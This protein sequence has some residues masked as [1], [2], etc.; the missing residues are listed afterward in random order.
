MII[1]ILQGCRV[2]RGMSSA[3]RLPAAFLLVSSAVLSAIRVIMSNR[4]RGYGSGA[5]A[6]RGDL[7]ALRASSF[8]SALQ[9][10]GSSVVFRGQGVD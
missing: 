9:L 10:D 4:V 5:S 8:V 7:A 3:D 1:R 2:R 6:C